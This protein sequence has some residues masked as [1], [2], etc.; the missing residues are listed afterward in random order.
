L[1][2]SVVRAAESRGFKMVL[3]FHDFLSV[4]PTGTFFNHRTKCQCHLKPLSAACVTTNC[5]SRSYSHKLWRVGRQVVQRSVGQ[6]PPEDGDFITVSDASDRLIRDFLP[7]RHHLHHVQNFTDVPHGEAV[8]VERNDTVIYVGRM[9][10]EKGPTLL[11]ECAER[12][13]LRVVFVGD[14]DLVGA[15]RERC[16]SAEITGWLE[17]EQVRE[18]LRESRVLVLPSLWFETQ[19]LVVA[20]AAAMGVPSIVP[21]E[22]GARDWVIDGETGLWFRGGSVDD[23]CRAVNKVMQEPAFAARMGQA[24]YQKFWSAPSTV[25]RHAEELEVVYESILARGTAA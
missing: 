22:S 24:A 20:E 4:C 5:D 21:D 23:L 2:S 15:V 13:K 8:P 18:R 19:G 7:R 17:A 14:G 12:L 1:S 3:T 16:P 10:A 25:A 9:A 11:A 6:L